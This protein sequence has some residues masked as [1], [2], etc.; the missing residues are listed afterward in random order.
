MG[1]NF[2]GEPSLI[3]G[4]SVLLF[5][6]VGVGEGLFSLFRSLGEIWDSMILGETV[7]IFSSF[8][9]GDSFYSRLGD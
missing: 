5:S 8:G 7:F 6:K 9:V 2:R 1:C 4:E 3:L